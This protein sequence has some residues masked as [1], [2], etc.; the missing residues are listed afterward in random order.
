MGLKGSGAR[1]SAARWHPVAACRPLK[2]LVAPDWIPSI[3]RF[4]IHLEAW[5]L[6]AWRLEGLE[7]IGGGDGGDG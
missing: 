3:L 4:Q 6:D 7:L 1:M 2:S 5:C